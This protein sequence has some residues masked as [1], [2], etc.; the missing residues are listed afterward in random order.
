MTVPADFE[1]SS[2]HRL[3]LPKLICLSGTSYQ[4]SSKCIIEGTQT[5]RSPSPTESLDYSMFGPLRGRFRRGSFPGW[6]ESCG[7]CP[8]PDESCSAASGPASLGHGYVL[9]TSFHRCGKRGMAGVRRNRLPCVSPR[10]KLLHPAGH[11]AC[12]S[13]RCRRLSHLGQ[14]VEPL[15][16]LEVFLPSHG[17][18]GPQALPVE[19]FCLCKVSSLLCRVCVAYQA[20]HLAGLG[21]CVRR[22]A[23]D[24]VSARDNV[25]VRRHSLG[26]RASFVRRCS[27]P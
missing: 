6:R 10:R 18:A 19:L 7:K 1:T 4:T 9:T 11:S 23:V 13:G 2:V 25:P 15:H 22:A 5:R 12:C 21:A 27:S 17:L 3:R 16:D 24:A 8:A 26:S 14:E 20:R